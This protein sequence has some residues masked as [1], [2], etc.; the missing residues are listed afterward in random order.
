MVARSMGR[1]LESSKIKL[2]RRLYQRNISSDDSDNASSPTSVYG[3][4]DLVSTLEMLA[5]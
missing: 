4:Y 3:R 1:R 2:Y 5:V